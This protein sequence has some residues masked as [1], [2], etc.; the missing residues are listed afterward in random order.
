MDKVTHKKPV[1]MDDN[2][3]DSGDTNDILESDQ[4]CMPL[5]RFLNWIIAKRK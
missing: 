4:S 3:E 1:D 5:V 2:T